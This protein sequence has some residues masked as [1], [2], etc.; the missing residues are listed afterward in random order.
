TVIP[1][2][3]NTRAK[4]RNRFQP[5]QSPPVLFIWLINPNLKKFTIFNVNKATTIEIELLHHENIKLQSSKQDNQRNRKSQEKS[6][7]TKGTTK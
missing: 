1:R 7:R 5:M 6:Q 2:K 4:A 3:S